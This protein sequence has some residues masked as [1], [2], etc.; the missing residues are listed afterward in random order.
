LGHHEKVEFTHTKW[1]LLSNKTGL[2]E[3]FPL[4]EENGV[5]LNNTLFWGKPPRGEKPFLK[6]RDLFGVFFSSRLPSLRVKKGGE[7]EKE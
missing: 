2:L 6:D 1:G 7:R 5:V 4:P 3:N